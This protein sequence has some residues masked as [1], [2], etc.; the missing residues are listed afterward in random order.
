MSGYSRTV[1]VTVSSSPSS[2]SAFST[3]QRAYTAYSANP[4][5]KKISASTTG[6]SH[7]RRSKARTAASTAEPTAGTI[8]HP[9]GMQI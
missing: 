8:S 3:V 5:A 2:F 1:Q 9:V 6:R 4:K 7:L